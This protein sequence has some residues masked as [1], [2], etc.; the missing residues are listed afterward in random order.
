MK[1]VVTPDNAQPQTCVVCHDPH[2]QGATSGEP[3]TATVRFMDNTLLLPAGF[4]AEVVGK[5]AICIT[6]HN[7]RNGVHNIDIAVTSYQ[8]PHAAAQGD[9]LMGENAYFVPTDSR[10]PHSYITNTCVT[11]HL[12]ESPPPAEYSFQ[13]GGTNHAFKANADICGN[14]HTKSLNA[15]GLQANFEGKLAELAGQMSKYL[16]NK[17]PDQFTVMDY[18]P[19]DY[20]GKP[21][22]IKSDPLIISK[23]NIAKIEPSE[24]HGQQGYLITLKA[25]VNVNYKAQGA[26]HT[27]PLSSLQVQLADMTTDG[28]TT[29]IAPTDPLVKSGWN[30]FL[31]QSDGSKACIIP[32]LS[33]MY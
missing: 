5:G 9:V 6:C 19:H 15:G 23:N 25:V 1:A 7:T 24:L 29:V 28:K 10:S 12:D 33:S 27:S 22:D 26:Q 30:Y 21:Y 31:V 11:C 16:L 4:K 8:A 18:T 13:L 32:G 2:E 20:N 3:N 17:L 14:C